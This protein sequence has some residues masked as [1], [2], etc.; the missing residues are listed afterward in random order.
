MGSCATCTCII[1]LRSVSISLHRGT[2]SSYS[3][4]SATDA[5]RTILAVIRNN[6][7]KDKDKD[8]DDDDKDN[9]S[10]KRHHRYQ[11]WV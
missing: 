7:D 10:N 11:F 5:R 3:T 1:N 6:Q 2:T 4:A 8:K 9:S